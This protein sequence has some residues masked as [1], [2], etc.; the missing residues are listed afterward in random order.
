MVGARAVSGRMLGVSAP[1]AALAFVA[2]SPPARAAEGDLEARVKALEERIGK[3]EDQIKQKDAEIARLREK[4]ER[5]EAAPQPPL[6]GG[7]PEDPIEKWRD[8]LG[9]L[10]DQTRRELEQWGLDWGLPGRTFRNP[11]GPIELAPTRRAFLGIEMEEEERGVRIAS[12]VPGS[13]A[14]QA[15][16]KPGDLL[17]EI[18]GRAV[19]SA[20]EVAK[21]IGSRE[22]GDAVT[23]AVERDG[24]TLNLGATLAAPKG[25]GT[26]Y[27]AP[28]FR[29]SPFG[30]RNGR[31]AAPAPKDMKDMID[32]EVTVPGG[33][34]RVSFSAPGLFMSDELAKQLKLTE[35]ERRDVE[36]AFAE[37]R[38]GLAAKV[39]DETAKTNGRVD[40][41]TVTRLRQEAEAKARD[42]LVKKLPGEKLAGLERAQAEA[43]A[44]SSVSV[45]TR[46]STGGG[47]GEGDAEGKKEKKEEPLEKLFEHAQ[48]F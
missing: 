11:R 6:R 13:P 44:R 10:D 2:A 36:A 28:G 46:S 37:A 3:L 45:S 14:E 31:D 9:Q 34:T 33:R 32:V 17:V 5:P 18:D 43:A 30:R 41:A 48:E 29:L 35:A 22:P 12:V 15:G 38:E 20:A 47:A 7:G 42:L 40:P 24:Q 27:P 26:P 21:R 8:Q 16:M 4:L 1:L 25:G 23:I 39:S 19:F